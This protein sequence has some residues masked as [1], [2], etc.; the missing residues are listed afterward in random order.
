MRCG[1]Y[2]PAI[3]DDDGRGRQRVSKMRA[4]ESVAGDDDVSARAFC[5]LAE[6]RSTLDDNDLPVP[7]IL[8]SFLSPSL[9]SWR[10]IVLQ[11]AEEE[12]S[13]RLSLL[14]FIFIF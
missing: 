9:E 5:R 2:S 6:S 1:P 3:W 13:S 12:F 4:V 14:F 10:G 11:V 8:S 7:H